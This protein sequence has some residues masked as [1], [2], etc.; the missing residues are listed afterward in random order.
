MTSEP[1]FLVFHADR[2]TET[3]VRSCLGKLANRWR[4]E[5][6]RNIKMLSSIGDHDVVLID[7]DYAPSQGVSALRSIREL[8]SDVA[9]VVA[10]SNPPLNQVVHAIRLGT[11]DYVAKPIDNAQLERVLEGLEKRAENRAAK[12]HNEH[13]ELVGTS[14][15]MMQVKRL[16]RRVGRSPTSTVLLTGESGTGKSLAAQSVHRHSARAGA[17]FMNITCSALVESILESQLFG[18]ERGAFTDARQSKK[19][20]LE[21]ADGGTVFL[22]EVGEMS[23]ALQAKLLRFLEDHTFKRVGGDQDIGVDVRIVAATNRDL[24]KDVEQGR[25]RE[26]LYYRLNVVPIELPALR[27]RADDVPGL[28]AHFIQHFNPRLGTCVQGLS[29][30]ALRMLTAYPWPGNVRELRNYIER[31]MLFAD[32]RRELEIDDFEF[33]PAARAPKRVFELPA[34]GCDLAVVERQLVVQALERAGGNQTLAA[35]LLHVHRDQIRY[36]MKKF[37]LEHSAPNVRSDLPAAVRLEA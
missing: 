10:S 32:D 36:R 26:D 16:L 3:S 29:R 8:D 1:S 27:R 31:A 2:Q 18:H 22:D 5:T 4:V 20:L 34:N 35:K 23:P 37:G 7:A 12:R 28:C 24:G 11:N 14:S 21:R 30:V 6:G 25:F 17:P 9:V 33:G 15:L 19:G 13:D